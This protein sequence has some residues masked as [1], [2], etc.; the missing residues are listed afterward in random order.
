MCPLGIYLGIF[1]T[2]QKVNGVSQK[3]N[4]VLCIYCKYILLRCTFYE[5]YIMPLNMYLFVPWKNDNFEMLRQLL[6]CGCNAG[7]TTRFLKW[8]GTKKVPT[9][10]GRQEKIL[11]FR[12]LKWPLIV[13]FWLV[14]H[15]K[16]IKQKWQEEF[17]FLFILFSQKVG[18]GGGGAPPGPPSVIGPVM[19]S[20]L[21]VTRGT[22][23]IIWHS[24]WLLSMVAHEGHPMSTF[25]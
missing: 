12:P 21:K 9:M 14:F 7:R 18:G 22:E 20:P 13:S 17:L 2:W 24:R 1:R 19:C 8:G 4:E 11:R 25:I 10:V 23:W 6:N 3:L 5:R 16:S 15:W